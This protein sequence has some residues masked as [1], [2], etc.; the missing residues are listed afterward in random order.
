VVFAVAAAAAAAAASEDHG[1][2]WLEYTFVDDEG[3]RTALGEA[4]AQLERY[5]LVVRRKRMFTAAQMRRWPAL[6]VQVGQRC[7]LEVESQAGKQHRGQGHAKGGCLAAQG[8]RRDVHLHAH[9]STQMK[10]SSARCKFV[11]SALEVGS[12]AAGVG[13]SKQQEGGAGGGGDHEQGVLSTP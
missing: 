11:I 13:G 5:G 8:A 3:E 6:E 4:A 9:S 1:P 7:A 2:V 10:I 12:Q